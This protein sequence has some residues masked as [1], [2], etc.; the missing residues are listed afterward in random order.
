M[1][2][3]IDNITVK[4]NAYSAVS[5]GQK[6]LPNQANHDANE[7]FLL[8][9]KSAEKAELEV[10]NPPKQIERQPI[11]FEDRLKQ[12]I[13]ADEIRRLMYL[14]TPFARQMMQTET[15][16]HTIDRQA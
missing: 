11:T 6:A 7:V 13:S 15:K 3:R 1:D 16:G 14:Y 5:V 2:I 12:M 4:P 9:K 8:Q 10:K